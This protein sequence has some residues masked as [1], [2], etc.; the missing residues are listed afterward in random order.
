MRPR[1]AEGALC[2]NATGFQ[3]VRDKSS[4]GSRRHFRGR[5]AFQANFPLL[6]AIPGRCPGLLTV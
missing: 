5:I 2:V 6:P 4:R 1:R 3:P